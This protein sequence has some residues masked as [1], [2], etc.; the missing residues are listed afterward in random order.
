MG[1]LALSLPL[2][3]CA[4]AP[5][6]SAGIAT[7][8]DATSAAP[9]I[10]PAGKP[11]LAVASA[12]SNGGNQPTSTEKVIHD[13]KSARSS[14]SAVPHALDQVAPLIPRQVLFG[15]PDKQ[16]ARISHDGKQLAYMA[17][18]DGVMNVWVGPIDNPDAA[19]PVTQEKVRP[20]PGYFW[21]Y[22]NT[23][24]LYA[25]DTGGDENFHVFA[26]NL[27][28][29]KTTDITPLKD[30]SRKIDIATAEADRKQTPEEEKVR[31]EIQEV[32]WKQPD[33]V[34]V[35]L[36]ERNPQFH[37]LYLV[38]I[39]T[40]EHKLVQENPEY[41]GFLTDEDFR[42]RFAS[43]MTPD[44]GS[45][46][47]KPDDKGG[48]KEFIKIGMD[49]SMTTSPAGFDESGDVMYLL[50]S[51][52]RDTGSLKT[53]NLKTG[54]EKL[55][56]ENPLADVGGI[57]LHPTKNT[58]QG[59]SFTYERTKWQF[60]D[61]EVEADYNRLKKLADGEIT[62]ASRTLDDRH[63]IV[64][65][66]MDDGPVRYYYFNRDSQEP[67]FLFT[68][69][70]ALEA[71]PL[72][73]M[74]SVVIEARDGLK[75]VS[76]L[77]LPPGSDLDGDGHPNAPV[78]MVLNVHGGPWARD[79][80]GFDPE[81]QLLANRG[82]AVLSVNYRGS[83]G[84]GKQFINAANKEWAGKMHDDLIDAVDWAVREKIA[85]PEKVAIYGG[86]YGG[87][88][89]LVGLTF[90]PDKFACGV[91]IVGPSSLFTLINSIPPYWAPALDMFKTRVGDP[92]TADG[93]ELLESRSPL[94]KVEN[95]KRP[96]LVGQGQNDQRVKVDEANQIVY[97][98]QQKHIPVTYVLFP[99]E[100]H[101]FHRPENSLAFNAVAE[102]FLAEHLGGRYEPIG[103]AF[104]G[105]TITVPAGESNIPGLKERMKAIGTTTESPGIGH[106][107]IQKG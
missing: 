40:G 73:K 107:P 29:G 11:S 78:P 48:W 66:L 75:L 16:F 51:R 41:A 79:S 37:D 88:A 77:T 81:H 94:T 3:G 32:S 69:R 80:W 100:G 8:S 106:E 53:L 24:I 42:V 89:T 43:Q 64:A 71:Q 56:A 50:D 86:S 96:L 36:N 60:Y 17:P 52:G 84:F 6:S 45:L 87:Y 54:E 85:D 31:A 91:D 61:K 39:N 14:T 12:S 49:D 93:K 76:Y 92:T 5:T 103:N 7:H 58:I 1:L 25:Q 15:N 2:A 95:I 33:K 99:D 47:L 26:V 67:K 44:G 34:L 102:A 98:M 74:H 55:V 97:A 23:H 21:A 72:Q 22:T 46:L 10:V 90:T 28:T 82:Y 105:S 9:E 19:K 68:N 57:M 38:D 65:F 59:V 18:V 27:A 104:T 20:I 83:T 70:K 30:P 4:P 63:W 62:I 35:A 13:V 101:G